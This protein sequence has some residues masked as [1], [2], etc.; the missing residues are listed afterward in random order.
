MKAAAPNV[1]VACFDESMNIDGFANCGEKKWQWRGNVDLIQICKY[2]NKIS[3]QLCRFSDDI[4]SNKA[5]SLL[6]L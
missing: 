4:V 1:R 2:I 3:I 5:K 6:A